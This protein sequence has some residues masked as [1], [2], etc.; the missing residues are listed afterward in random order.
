MWFNGGM[1]DGFT[2]Y[3]NTAN[4]GLTA[5]IIGDY[6]V[7]ESEVIRVRQRGPLITVKII[8]ILDE[9]ITKSRC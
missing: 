1:L 9:V 8:Y 7:R 6:T 2:Q 3:L 5:S 4:S